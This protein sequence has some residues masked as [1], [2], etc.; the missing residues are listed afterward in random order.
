MSPVTVRHCRYLLRSKQDL[1][2]LAA[3][4]GTSTFAQII[5]GS[6]PPLSLVSTVP[7]IYSRGLTVQV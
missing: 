7:D 5:A 6:F 1:L 2:T 4:V 3:T